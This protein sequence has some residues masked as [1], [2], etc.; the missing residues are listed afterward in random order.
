MLHASLPV[1]T[2]FGAEPDTIWL[3]AEIVHCDYG[4]PDSVGIGVR[5][6]TPMALQFFGA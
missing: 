4:R 3:P 6:I 1:M 2:A 5:F